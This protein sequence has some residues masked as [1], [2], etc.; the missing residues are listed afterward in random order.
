MLGL[1]SRAVMW[2]LKGQEL[3]WGGRSFNEEE[4]KRLGGRWTASAFQTRAA[5][6]REVLRSGTLLWDRRI[7]SYAQEGSVGVGSESRGP[8]GGD[9]DG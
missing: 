6:P 5:S 9:K 1:E 3:G 7:G 4:V 2:G 8:G